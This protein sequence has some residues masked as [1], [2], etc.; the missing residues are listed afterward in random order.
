MPIHPKPAKSHRHALVVFVITAVTFGPLP[1]KAQD[2]LQLEE[3]VVSAQRREQ[4]LQEVPISI[5]VYTGAEI[6]LQGY[7][8]MQDLAKFSP[9]VN[10]KNGDED[11]VAVIRGFGTQGNAINLQSATPLF[12]DGIHFGRRSMVQTAFLDTERVEVLKGPQPLFF[13]M[14]ATGGA[15]NVISRMPT[16][17]WEGELGAEFGNY[18]RREATAA[19]G[20]PLTDTLGIRMAGMLEQEAGVLKN[21]ITRGREP[22]YDVLAGRSLLR[23]NPGDLE[24]VGKFE[25]SRSRNGPSPLVG[26]L[27]PGNTSGYSESSPLDGGVDESLEG[28]FGRDHSA[29]ENPPGGIN[30]LAGVP[31]PEEKGANCFEDNEYGFS[32][33]GPFMEPV[34]GVH[35]QQG[36]LGD[37][38][39][40]I[41]AATE[42][43]LSREAP[44]GP[45]PFG[46]DFGGSLGK[47]DIDTWNALL[48]IRYRLPNGMIFNS[49]TGYIDFDRAP[50]IADNRESPF[51][52]NHFHRTEHVTQWSEQVRLESRAEGYNAGPVNIEFM[53]GA[54]YQLMYLDSAGNTLRATPR[55]AQ[56]F[57]Y[58]WED[59]RWAS[60]FGELTLNMLDRQL[61]LA[62][63][64]RYTDVEKTTQILGFGAQWIVDEAPCDADPAINPAQ[65]DNPATCPLD[66]DF[67]RI[68]TSLTEPTFVS[69]GRG[70]VR[71]D[72]PNITVDPSTADMDNLWTVGGWRSTTNVPLNWRGGGADAVGLTA[73]EFSVRN[74]PWGPCEACDADLSSED[75]SVDFQVVLRYTPE[76]LDG[77]H[78]VYAKYAEAFRGP[79]ADTGRGS[80]PRDPE[81]MLADSETTSAWE[82]GI[83]GTLLNSRMRYD[84]TVFTQ[85]FNDLQAIGTVPPLGPEG[86]IF[87]SESINVDQKTDGIEF[88]TTAL[89][90]NNLTFSLAGAVMNSTLDNFLGGGCSD[91]QII[92]AAANAIN[93]PAGRPAEELDEANDVLDTIGPT[94]RTHAL[95]ADIPEDML[96]CRLI[97]EEVEGGTI[98]ASTINRNGVGAAHTPDWKFVV[99]LTYSLPVL[100]R[101]EVFTDIRGFYSDSIVI[102]PE[103]YDKKVTFHKHGDVNIQVGLGPQDGTWRVLGFVRNLL[104]ATEQYNEEYDLQLLG[105]GSLE[106]RDNQFRRYGVRFEY[107][108]R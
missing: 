3:I 78:T 23:W 102:D 99:G 36:D 65:D 25:I 50:S 61:T 60:G 74:G 26:C 89:V 39:L 45:G 90:T 24:V 76:A 27:T 33:A 48:D 97:E 70:V 71:I 62:G 28:I 42:G 40:D 58:V 4:T 98:E 37:G 107:N 32:R 47:E 92:A 1:L 2:D 7:K 29:W 88:S 18:G 86:D 63:G 100:D 73:A 46:F 105:L 5:N 53:L 19:F 104:E 44:E 66:D 56:R 34:P 43:Y 87:N 67:V 49:E 54:H 64:L 8:Q 91:D 31:L 51:M 84:A 10:V 17:E 22:Q 9:S 108:F 13:G 69:G 95:N 59:S 75:D 81:D 103:E 94:R 80:I 106:N 55:R 15:F 30:G 35:N 41:R 68:D 14:N 11:S 77:N 20:G 6:Q 52:V 101:F 38:M 93:N 16:P 83:R 85:K 57:N 72:S 79:V 21:R 12:L 96:G 82:A